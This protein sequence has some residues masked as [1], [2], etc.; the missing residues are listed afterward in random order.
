MTTAGSVAVA[1]AA[2]SPAERGHAARV[3]AILTALAAAALASTLLL[4]ASSSRWS[5]RPDDWVW[6]L[7]WIA[8]CPAGWYVAARGPHRRFGE[9]LAASGAV[10]VAGGLAGAL[11]HRLLLDGG[12]RTLGVV[13]AVTQRI[14]SDLP[15][16]LLV[17]AL[18]L[19]PDGRLPGP[20]WRPV[21][22]V[23]AGV[24]AVT[25]GADLFRQGPLDD[26]LPV[27]NPLT[28]RSAGALLDLLDTATSVA[29][30]GLVVAGLVAV[31]LRRRRAVEA[32]RAAATAFWVGA[33]W[34]VGGTVAALLADGLGWHVPFAVSSVLEALVVLLAPAAAA[35]AVVQWIRAGAEAA[36]NRSLTY[37][38]VA[39]V[40]VAG[41][42]GTVTVLGRLVQHRSAFGVSL[43]AT[44]LIAVALGPL[45]LGVQRGVERAMVGSRGSPYAALTTL[46]SQMSATPSPEEALAAA[47]RAVGESLR[48][49]HVTLSVTAGDGDTVVAEHGHA[50]RTVLDVPLVHA[51]E[52]VGTLRLAGRSAYERFNQAD[53]RLLAD[54]ADRIAG[55]VAVVALSEELRRSRAALV[56]ARE[57][58]RRRIRR[59]LHDGVG[60]VLA[61]A[62]LALGRAQRRFPATDERHASL[63][64]A[65]DELRQA[66]GDVRELVHGL[67]PP[68]LDELGLVGALR[69]RAATLADPVVIRMDADDI[70]ALPAAVEVAAYRIA[71]EAMTNAV[72]HGAAGACGVRLSLEGDSLRVSVSDDGRG[73]GTDAQAGVGMASMRERAGELGGS[74]RIS[75]APGDTE[76]VA[77]LPI[78]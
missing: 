26:D 7:G 21:A 9:L 47:T 34:L 32:D 37:L 59:D 1:P 56:R 71:A 60:P 55:T 22:V 77:C 70:G 8:W 52:R 39:G 25:I 31:G 51:G 38:A 5:V 24:A 62:V 10:V 33:C 73:F 19:F 14:L 75:S 58:E 69:Q 27:P 68:A 40:V 20:R 23:T 48:S 45:K 17:A 12:P 64:E 66:I 63:G 30:A 78:R 50:A 53:Q 57:E 2:T 43:V 61:S 46:G 65:V 72:R 54:F 76:V 6:L 42:A 15:F 29:L 3:P 74:L 4:G 11:A 35:A 67:R 28:A 18:L 49:P 16:F 41:Y 13:A 36:L 44:G